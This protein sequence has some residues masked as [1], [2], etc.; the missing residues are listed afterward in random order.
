MTSELTIT[1][2]SVTPLFLGGA[3]PRG[4]PELRPPSFRGAMRYWLRAALG[5]VCGDDEAGL[6]V[7][8]E[9][10]A[11]VFGSTDEQCGGASSITLRVKGDLS[12]PEEYQRAPAVCVEKNGERL[13]QPTGRDYL[14]WSMPGFGGE[15]NRKYYPAGYKF[16]LNLSVRPGVIDGR[17]VFQQA[18]GA[19]WLLVQLG[20]IGS[21]SR[22]TAGSLSVV[23]PLAVEGLSFALHSSDSSGIVQELKEG[24]NNV[25]RLFQEHISPR[26]LAQPAEFDVLHSGVCKVWVLGIWPSSQQAVEAIGAAMRDFRTYR[27]P[28]HSQVAKW[29]S[30]TTIPTVERAV[31]GLPL[32]FRYSNNGP[33]G[34][35]Q[36]RTKP[37]EQAIDRRASPLWLKISKTQTGA[38]VG[39]A[40]LFKSRFLPE[41]EK[42]HEQNEKGLPLPLPSSYALIEQF[43]KEGFS[44]QE[45]TFD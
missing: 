29:L 3:N 10:E 21:R 27:E 26:R 5:G 24:L 6:S 44:A 30:G 19:L 1:M 22:R 28:D 9:A 33:K 15:P 35:V 20:G 18:I 4:A 43:I 11:R 32:P 7:A 2:E 39:I 31:F 41:G 45:V 36:G 17:A 42:L 14:Y 38:F 8:R 12:K 40:T 37:K 23:E 25:R 34:V 13:R 16:S